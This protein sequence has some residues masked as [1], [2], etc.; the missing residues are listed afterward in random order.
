VDERHQPRLPWRMNVTRDARGF[1][2]SADIV[3]MEAAPA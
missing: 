2:S 1:I 3:P